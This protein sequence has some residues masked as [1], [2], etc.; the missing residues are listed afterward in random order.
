MVFHVLNR[1]VRR[2]G[3]FDHPGDY[4]AFLQLVGDAQQRVP[5]RCLSYCV[6]PNHFHFVL[7][8][9]ADGDLSR[10]M[11]WLTTTHSMRWHVWRGTSGTGHVYQGRYKAFPIQQDTHFHRVCRYVE[12]NPLR[13][14]LV[15]RAE[16]WT[17]SSLAQR[18]GSRLPI[19][20]A[21]WPV[22]RPDDWLDTVQTESPAETHEV[23]EALVRSAPYGPVGW[24]ERTAVQLGLIKSLHQKGRPWNITAPEG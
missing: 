10:F 22:P 19:E 17:W 3:L 16:A 7:W 13:A 14:G 18:C 2:L 12:R 23:R 5:V 15:P 4:R 21:D 1:G 24:R 8:P 11:F 9:K 20:L 6:M